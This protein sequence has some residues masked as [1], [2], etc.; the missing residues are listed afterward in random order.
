MNNLQETT[1][2]RTSIQNA[3]L[4]RNEVFKLAEKLMAE[5]VYDEEEWDEYDDDGNLLNP[6]CN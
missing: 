6:P 4:S 2:I 5:G 1:Q 3:R